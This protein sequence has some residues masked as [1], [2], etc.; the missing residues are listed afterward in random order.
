M[1]SV[2]NVLEKKHLCHELVVKSIEVNTKEKAILGNFKCVWELYTISIPFSLMYRTLKLPR[3][4]TLSTSA[5]MVIFFK[6]PNRIWNKGSNSWISWVICLKIVWYLF[7]VITEVEHSCN[8][9]WS[10]L[11]C[12][13]KLCT[14]ILNFW[15]VQ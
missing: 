10:N 13:L 7:L 1:L 8:P 14:G 5:K 6:Q 4:W 9:H 2:D 15:H 3:Q 11:D 12:A